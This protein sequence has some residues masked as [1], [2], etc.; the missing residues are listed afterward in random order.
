M[1]EAHIVLSFDVG[2]LSQANHNYLGTGIPRNV[3]EPQAEEEN[4]EHSKS[5]VSSADF[6]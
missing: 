3:V 2:Q 4:K 5:I 1:T 6:A